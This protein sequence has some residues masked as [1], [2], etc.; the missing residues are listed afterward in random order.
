M[1][2]TEVVCIYSD[3]SSYQEMLLR[4]LD[5]D[6]DGMATQIQVL[7]EQVKHLDENKSLIQKLNGPWMTPDLAF[8][9]LFSYEFFDHTHLFLCELLNQRPL[10]SYDILYGLL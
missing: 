7:Y 3:L 8:C 9:V 10:T 1:Y 6:Q 2:K 4:I 5:T